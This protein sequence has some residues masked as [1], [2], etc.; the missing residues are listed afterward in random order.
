[1]TP[2]SRVVAVVLHWR[3]EEEIR[4][5]LRAL[6]ASDHP[7]LDVVVVDNGSTDGSGARIR[8][9]FPKIEHLRSE[10]NLGYT[11]GNNR[12]W[13]YALERG[14]VDHF[15]FVNDDALVEEDA[16]SALVARA[17]EEPDVGAVAPKILERGRPE[18]IWFG[19]GRL[20]R[21][22]ATGIHLREGETDA[23]GSERAEE[24]TFV[25]GC[26]LLVPASVMEELG[27]FEEDFFAYIEDV[28][29]S[30]RLRRAGYRLWYEPAARVHHAVGAEGSEPS[31]RQIELRDRNRRR[32][33]RRRYGRA[34]GLAFAAFFYPSRL[35]HLARYL[36]RGDRERAGGIWRGMTAP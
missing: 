16:V 5:C 10:R 7:A 14:P 23:T 12:G 8:R 18:R 19:G 21:L 9:D 1:M 31:P 36:V 2:P 35:V 13:R 22:R 20:S 24:V 4:A 28:D 32:L 30:L 33:V 34:A 17:E 26:C 15:L 29:L 11:G 27:G 3:R 6:L 25:T